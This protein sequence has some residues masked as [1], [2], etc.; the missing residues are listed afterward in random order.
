MSRELDMINHGLRIALGAPSRRVKRLVRDPVRA[1]AHSIREDAPSELAVA[2]R[3]ACE[4]RGLTL[5]Q[6]RS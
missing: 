5:P 6:V 1:P 3:R 2:L 4:R